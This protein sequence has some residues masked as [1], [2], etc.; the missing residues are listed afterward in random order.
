VFEE[1]DS[2]N[3][4]DDGD[5]DEHIRKR[6]LRQKSF[7]PGKECCSLGT[8]KKST[9]SGRVYASQTNNTDKGKEAIADERDGEKSRIPYK[10]MV[11]DEPGGFKMKAKSRTQNKKTISDSSLCAT[12][13]D[14]HSRKTKNNKTNPSEEESHGTKKTTKKKRQAKDKKIKSKLST[15]KKMAD[16]LVCGDG[17][18]KTKK[19]TPKKSNPNKQRAPKKQTN[20]NVPSNGGDRVETKHITPRKVTPKKA[21]PKKTTPKITTPEKTTPK[22]ISP[23][24]Q[25]EASDSDVS[26]DGCDNDGEID[27]IKLESDLEKF[28]EANNLTARNVKSILRH[29]LAVKL[30]A[31]ANFSKSDSS[32]I[33]SISPS[34][35]QPSSLT[36][37][38]LAS[39]CL[40][41][42]IFFGVVFSGVVIFGVVFFGVAFFGVTFLGVICFVSTLSPPFE[43][44]LSFV[45]FF[46]ALC[47][48][49]LLF[50]G[51]CFLVLIIPSP[52]TKVSAIFFGVL[53][54]LFIFLS[55]ACLF[56]FVV[57]LVP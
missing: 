49:G 21:T 36:S 24:R 50:L 20:D 12:G 30:F 29:V 16:T 57:F 27:L 15:P 46:G 9:T 53:S 32:F 33:K 17:I 19:Q 47:L 54:L 7:S 56:F 13:R 26:D 10:K 4:V 55:L 38:S 39:I 8:G 1:E 18:I 3:D 6:M 52:H 43:G 23:T 5:G 14:V 2:Y 42:D 31:S 28:A 51:V 41:G 11:D 44:T 45:C 37:L 22:K 40:V 25:I 35:S 34:L 48:F